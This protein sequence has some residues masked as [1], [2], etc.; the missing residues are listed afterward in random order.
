MALHQFSPMNSRPLLRRTAPPYVDLQVTPPSLLQDYRQI[1]FNCM[2]TPVLVK[3]TNIYLAT[4]PLN[5]CVTLR[6]LSI[7]CLA[8]FTP[9]HRFGSQCLK[10]WN[11][12]AWSDDAVM[13]AHI[14]EIK[15]EAAVL[16]HIAT[17]MG[18]FE[19]K[20][21]RISPWGFHVAFQRRGFAL[22]DS[23]PEPWSSLCTSRVWLKRQHELKNKKTSGVWCKSI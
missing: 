22:P 15:A 7:L 17:G 9:E 11:I 23:S 5:R 1:E 8:S 10:S 3:K 18:I 2:S 20:R 13:V 16:T 6:V 19:P 21:W 14:V 4:I 12:T